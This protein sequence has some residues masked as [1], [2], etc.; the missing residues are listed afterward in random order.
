MKYPKTDKVQPHINQEKD[1]VK[2]LERGRS[3]F[4]IFHTV[5]QRSKIS[6]QSQFAKTSSI[7]VRQIDTFSVALTGTSLGYFRKHNTSEHEVED[8]ILIDKL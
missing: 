7:P 2:I 4:S 8:E 3:A 6:T 1:S 5:S